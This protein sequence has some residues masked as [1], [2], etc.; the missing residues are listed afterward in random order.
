[1]RFWSLSP[2]SISASL[3]AAHIILPVA[4]VAVRRRNHAT[5]AV[6]RGIVRAANVGSKRAFAV[7][8]QCRCR[9]FVRPT[10]YYGENAELW[11]IIIGFMSGGRI[12]A[13]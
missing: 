8:Y 10:R 7:F 6:N 2:S 11:E 5:S 3:R 1:M 9:S 12:C 13:K 4:L